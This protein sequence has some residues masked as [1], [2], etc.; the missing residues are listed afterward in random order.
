MPDTGNSQGV[1][2]DDQT[3][4]TQSAMTPSVFSSNARFK[5]LESMLKQQHNELA[6][7]SKNSTSKYT[8]LEVQLQRL[9]DQQV[10]SLEHNHQTLTSITDLKVEVQQL[11]SLMH[12]IVS[13]RLSS[14]HAQAD[15]PEPPVSPVTPS[16]H[17]STMTAASRTQSSTHSLASSSSGSSGTSR[18]PP[19]K[20]RPIPT[21][22]KETSTITHSTIPISHEVPT[23]ETPP[24]LSSLALAHSRRPAS[25]TENEDSYL[26]LD[27]TADDI[28][29]P[30]PTAQADLD[31][32]YTDPSVP[33]GG[34][35][36]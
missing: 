3:C 34:E 14:S 5:E 33:D 21:S 12:R 20:P 4:S 35:N 19:K 30:I 10:R 1:E 18:R 15:S 24:I 16:Q 27:E 32:Q 9:S 28:L 31:M 22:T 2:T 26:H 17:T 11:T 23:V 25:P 29:Y 8:A 7:V 6:A 36:G 13:E